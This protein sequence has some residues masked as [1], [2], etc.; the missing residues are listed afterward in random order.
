MN[1]KSYRVLLYYM[2]VEIENL[3]EFASQHLELCNRLGLKGRIIVAKELTVQSGINAK[4]DEY[5]RTLKED[6]RFSKMVF[7][8]DEAD[9]HAFKMMHVRPRSELV[10]LQLED[11]VNPNEV[12]GKYLSPKDFLQ[13]MKKESTI[14]IDA[15]NDL[16]PNLLH[17]NPYYLSE[18]NICLL[19]SG[20]AQFT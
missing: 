18:H 6:S 13:A 2:Y 10:T 15:R 19:H 7:K 20:L 4:T 12:T 14:V 11:D 17:I 1:R 8:V 5:M 9:E 3:D 16:I